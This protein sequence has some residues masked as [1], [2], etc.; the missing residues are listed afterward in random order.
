MSILGNGGIKIDD[1]EKLWTTKVEGFNDFFAILGCNVQDCQD[2]I[3]TKWLE[4][5]Q[6]NLAD[7]I[8][9]ICL[10]YTSDAADE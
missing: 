3:A 5:N 8:F 2:R 10:L 4:I 1:L 7:K 6:D 9:S